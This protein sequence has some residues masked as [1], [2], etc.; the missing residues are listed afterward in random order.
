[1][2]N[3]IKVKI[4][5]EVHAYLNTKEKLFC[6]C[7]AN[8]EDFEPNTNICPICTGM[9]GVKPLLVNEE[10]LKKSIQVAH[11][12][13]CKI[14]NDWVFQRK[15]YDW[16]DM[17][18]GYQ[19]TISGTYTVPIGIEGKFEGIRIIE[20]H[21]EED[22]AK[23][24]PST[25]RVDYN[26]S[27]VPLIEIVTYPDFSNAKEVRNW[28]DKLLYT[29]E[30]LKLIKKGSIKADVNISVNVNGKQGERVEIKNVNSLKA[31]EKVINYEILR[32]KTLLLQGK[33]VKRETRAYDEVN[34][35]TIKMREK[36]TS[37]DYRFIPDLDILP[38]S[39]SDEF[40]K[41]TIEEL[42]EAPLKRIERFQKQYNLSY[43]EAY[44]LCLTKF[45][46]DLF[47]ELVNKNQEIKDLIVKT[48]KRD[49]IKALQLL[50]KNIDDLEKLNFD[51]EALVLLMKSFNNKEIT[52][53]VFQELIV[54]VLKG[55]NK[56]EIKKLI[57]E[58]KVVSNSDLIEKVVEDVIN[59]NPKAVNDYKNGEKKA[60]QFLFGQVMRKLKGRGD[61][62]LIRKLLEEKLDQ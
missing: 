54:E 6:S 19:R 11:I 16:P 36:E 3:N 15:H 33:E 26:R 7:S 51:K 50:N 22:P 52:N 48:L 8:Y 2:S 58:K 44:T 24:D 4:G 38:I 18:N 42:E 29:L 10:A 1:M 43:D 27:G 62:N 53:L 61:I 21:L 46:A 34:N 31:I 57:E 32:Q 30:Y 25:G 41:K 20:A 55:K 12:L 40:K 28:L 56:E 13:N 49:L 47:E 35:R 37:E 5:L 59:E 60:L 14:T 17:P 23:W 39:V 9:P 45:L